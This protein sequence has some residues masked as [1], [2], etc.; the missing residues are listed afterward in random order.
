MVFLDFEYGKEDLKFI[1]SALRRRNLFMDEDDKWEVQGP[2][3]DMNY[4]VYVGRAFE[5]PL[6]VY[7]TCTCN[8][9]GVGQCKKHL[10]GF[11]VAIYPR[12]VY[13]I[14]SPDDW[15]KVRQD[16]RITLGGRNP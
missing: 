4:Q 9:I 3:Q 7:T 2:R 12:A 6:P 5:K 13:E 8:T 14:Q 16:K 1:R 11:Y 10:N 15:L